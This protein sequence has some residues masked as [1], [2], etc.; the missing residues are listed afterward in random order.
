[1]SAAITA[2]RGFGEIH[3][4]LAAFYG[5]DQ[6][7][8]ASREIDFGLRWR[9]AGRSTYRCAFVVDTGELYLFEHL[10]SDGGGGMVFVH[11]HVSP[12][13]GKPE[14]FAGWPLRCDDENSL[15][16]LLER[17]DACCGALAGDAQ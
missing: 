3:A 17:A 16:W 6:R 7:R 4:S 8:W 5:G 9:G 15:A 2:L 14:T 12:D 1:M 11:E 10:R 13:W